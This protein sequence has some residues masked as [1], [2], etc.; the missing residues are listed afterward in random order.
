MGQSVCLNCTYFLITLLVRLSQTNPLTTQKFTAALDLP[1][2]DIVL[3]SS[4]Y[5]LPPL[6]SRS[7]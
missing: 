6:T 7:T 2:F 5:P 4:M 3:F 1:V